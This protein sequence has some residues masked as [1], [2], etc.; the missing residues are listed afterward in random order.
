MSINLEDLYPE[1]TYA[2]GKNG[3][4]LKITYYWTKEFNKGKITHTV[5]EVIT[6]EEYQSNIDKPDTVTVPT[7]E[8][9][10]AFGTNYEE[11][12]SFLND[13]LILARLGGTQF[14]KVSFRA[15][16]DFEGVVNYIYDNK[17]YLSE[18][19]KD[20]LLAIV[21]SYKNKVQP[22]S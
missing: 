12:E 20:A 2:I 7:G 22:L 14:L 18:I 6:D 1:E 3:D 5:N 13:P 10:Q 21:T 4:K 19:T 16:L 8:L 17:A 9:I 15:L 11:Q